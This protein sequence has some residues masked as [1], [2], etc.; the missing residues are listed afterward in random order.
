MNTVLLLYSLVIGY[1]FGDLCYGD[2]RWDI[3][4]LLIFTS[5]VWVI[6]F[7]EDLR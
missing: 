2:W 4:S 3:F 7:F 6:I 5:F 1:L